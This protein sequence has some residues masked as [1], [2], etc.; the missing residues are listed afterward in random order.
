M[1]TCIN[2]C[3]PELGGLPVVSNVQTLLVAGCFVLRAEINVENRSCDTVSFKHDKLSVT[4]YLPTSSLTVMRFSD[5]SHYVQYVY[6]V[7]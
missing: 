3:I 7:E 5:A 4:I 1:C 6:F 2:C